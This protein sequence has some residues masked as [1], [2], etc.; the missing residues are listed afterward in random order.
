MKRSGF[1]PK[2]RVLTSTETQ[3]SFETWKEGL[4]FNLTLDGTFEFLLDEDVV[5]RSYDTPNRGFQDDTT[6]TKEQMKTGKQKAA[7]LSLLLGTIAGYAPVISRLYITQEARSLNDIWKRLRIHYGFRKSGALILDLPSF[8]LEEDESPESLW[9]RM[10]AFTMDNL[11]QPS[12]NISHLNNTNI[13]ELMSPTLLNTIVVLW[14]QTIHRSLPLLVKQKYSTELRTKTLASIREDISESLN[15]MLSEIQGESVAS[16]SRSAPYNNPYRRNRYDDKQ[17]PFRR[18]P[19]PNTNTSSKFCAIC[20]T[21][22]RRS[23]HFLSECPFLPEAD[24]RFMSNRP[25]LRLVDAEDDEAVFYEGSVRNIKEESSPET[26]QNN[27]NE[28]KAR[29]RKVT[30]K[31]SPYLYVKFRNHPVKLTLDSGA[32]SNVIRLD[33]AREIGA[34]I[35]K[36]TSG[37]TQADGITHLDIAGEVHLIFHLDNLDLYFDGLVTKDLSDDVLAGVPFMDT[38]DVYA[39][40]AQR[41]V[42]FGDRSFSC[43]ISNVSRKADIIRVKES[44]ILLP[45][46]H[47]TVPVPEIF[48]EETHVAVEPRVDSPSCSYTKYQNC[49]IQPHVT[50]NVNKCISLLNH[51]QDPISLK[52]FEHIATVRA[53]EKL[54]LPEEYVKQQPIIGAT[55]SSKPKTLSE[56][57]HVPTHLPEVKTPTYKDIILNP[58]NTLSKEQCQRFKHIHSQ[59]STVFDGSSLGKYNGASGPLKVTINMGPTLPPQR[60]GRMPLYNRQQLEELQ[61]VC[62]ELEG[63]V[64]L[65]PE[66]VGVSCE[67]LNPSFLV[68][69]K[70]GKKRLVTAFG[71]VGEYAK[72]QPALMPDTNYV[73]RQISEFKELIVSD[74]S[75]AYWQMELDK[76]SMRFCGVATPFKG[77]RVYGRGAMGMPGTETALEEMM[78]RILGD[79]M[80]EGKVTK[81]ADDIYCG[82]SSV[83]NVTNNWEEV[84]KALERN[85]LRLSA[86]KTVVCPKTVQI[87]GWIWERGTL[88]ASPHKIST[89]S[90]IELPST[91]GKLRSYIGGVK[92]LSRTLKNYSYLLHPLEQAIAGK[93]SKEKVTWTEPLR[94]AFNQSQ[95]QLRSSETL[96]LPTRRDQIQIVTDASNIGIGAAMYVIRN[97]KPMIAGYFSSCFKQHQKGW[98]P[99]EAESLAINCAVSHFSAYIIDSDLQTVVLT[100]SLPCVMAY[101]KLKRG[102]FST[103]ARVST[104]LSSLCRF[105]IHLEHLKGK[106]NLYADLASRNPAQCNQQNCQICKYTQ[107]TI[108]SV[109]KSCSVKDVLNSS[110]P[111]PY[112]SRSGWYELQLTDE[113]LRRTC[114]HLKQGTTPS[115]KCTNINDV[116]RYL[117]VCKL[118]RDGLLIVPQYIPSIGRSNKIVVPRTYLHGLLECLHIKLDHPSKLQL[119]QIFSRAYYALDVD[120]A[121]DIVNKTCHTCVSLSDMPNRFLKQSSTTKPTTIGSNFSADVLKRSGQNI[122]VIREYVSSYTLAKLIWNEKASSIR[123]AL[124]IIT[125]ELKPSSSM[126]IT[127]KVDPA[128]AWRCLK[129]DPELLRNG[130]VLEIG[131]AK[132]R[133][134]NPVVDHA[135]KELHPEINK[136]QGDAR[137]ITERILAKAVQNLNCRLRGW[138]LSS[139]EI[140]TQRNQYNGEQLPVEDLRLMKYKETEK[141]K[142]HLPS[143]KFKARGKSVYNAGIIK[144]GDLIYINSDRDKLRSRDR[145]IVIEVEDSTCKVQKFTGS[146]LRAR[147]YTVNLA[148]ITKVQP[149]TFKNVNTPSDSDSDED[150]S[151]ELVSQH[152]NDIEQDEE[153]GVLEEDE[154]NENETNSDED[155]GENDEDEGENDEDEG[156]NNDDEGVN[157]EVTEATHT[158]RYGRPVQPPSRFCC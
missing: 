6:G 54:P 156:E 152:Q 72:P 69:K 89:L 41:K 74:L 8:Q 114:A 104:F 100:D 45:G 153:G 48:S 105:N 128:S 66:D 3:G 84:L 130:I 147:T 53:V 157:N 24:R 14:L 32:M 63:T 116:K 4:I 80:T 112:C 158:S 23:D 107:D 38:N 140:W 27:H 103:S 143:A 10:Y 78:T 154:D 37:A 17:P 1:A 98:M 43:D 2:C 145:Y 22:N 61:Q 109:V 136:V 151:S 65:K 92:F 11:L 81:L 88:K 125:S 25:K 108:E 55:I 44:T 15:S 64:L 16:V 58:H 28:P 148:D 96:T 134:K 133:N 144:K 42:F 20:D 115:R 35:Y 18:K 87:L 149:W 123:T 79:Q 85:G 102:L 127:I 68:N 7:I 5:W 50:E 46:D 97:N 122:L 31:N 135:I 59:R 101:K 60:K 36:T 141:E 26:N 82:G 34:K 62:D 56:S 73:L 129:D 29:V 51:T 132:M 139:R 119:K 126:N 19:P 124:L 150:S 93:E 9:E 111:V 120:A 95:I 76:N 138:G 146:Q 142:S 113:S 70:S 52:K 47:I 131:H 30:V 12:D 137:N 99:C 94:E 75:S 155:E 13:R 49:W 57:P 86:G 117:R 67:Y 39:R 71:T 110:A 83:E 118:D 40:P 121:L 77:I 33:F 21:A 91:V 90:T 106:E